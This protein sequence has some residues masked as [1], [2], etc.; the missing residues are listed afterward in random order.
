MFTQAITRRPGPNFAQGLTSH[1]GDPPH[2]ETMLAQHAAYVRTLQAAGL[3]VTQ[4]EPLP[5]FPDGYF[6]EDVAVILPDV[7]IITRPGATARRG[8]TAFM[9]PVLATLKPLQTIDPPGTLEG[10]D[11]LLIDDQLFIGISGRTN[12]SGADQ[13]AAIAATH[14]VTAVAVAVNDGLHLKSS[15]T[16]VG[17]NT[18]LL[19]E[20]FAFDPAFAA[21]THLIPPAVETA[22]ANTLLLNDTLIMPAGFPQTRRQLAE[23]GLPII[24]CAMSEVQKMDGGLTCL[25]LRF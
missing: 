25:S 9:E 20:A 11:V 23:L 2:Y 7:A 10:G 21:Y 24:E 17:S 5:D 18:L 22:V 14:G 15:V 6:V 3:M 12:R 8:E 19:T 16:Y 4:L 1:R 13:L